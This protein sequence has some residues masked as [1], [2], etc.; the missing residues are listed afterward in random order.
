MIGVPWYNTYV[1]K[2]L[3]GKVFE[4]FIRNARTDRYIM[5]CSIDAHAKYHK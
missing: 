4:R 5:M 3:Q 1:F 2:K